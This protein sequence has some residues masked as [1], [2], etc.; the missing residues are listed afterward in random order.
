[1]SELLTVLPHLVAPLGSQSLLAHVL[2]RLDQP[3]LSI[4]APNVTESG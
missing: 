2:L 4:V 1:V 3:A